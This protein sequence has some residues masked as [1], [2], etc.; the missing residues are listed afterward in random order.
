MANYIYT[1]T[2][3]KLPQAGN[4]FAMI[5]RHPMLRKPAPYPGRGSRPEDRPVWEVVGW[6]ELD[7]DPYVMMT[8]TITECRAYLL[9]LL[10]G[11]AI[12]EGKQHDA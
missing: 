9:T 1:N 6:E 4:F 12:W 5:L 3:Y 11:K 2:L 8:G 7:A 10:A